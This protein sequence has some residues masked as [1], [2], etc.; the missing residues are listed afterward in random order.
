MTKGIG[1][2][3]HLCP[4]TGLEFTHGN[5]YMDALSAA[6][7][8][9][10]RDL[11]DTREKDLIADVRREEDQK[12]EYREIATEA[13][14]PGDSSFAD[15]TTDLDN[16]AIGRDMNELRAIRRARDRMADGSY[17]TCMDCGELIPQQRLMAQP[18]AE[19][20]ARCQEAWE[21]GHPDSGRGATL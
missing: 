15:L 16:A 12:D 10:I 3:S 9:K 8:A 21:R 13:P 19:R 6:D 4:I 2:V 17:G 18:I 1:E 14:D 20:C 11:L 7:L 5:K